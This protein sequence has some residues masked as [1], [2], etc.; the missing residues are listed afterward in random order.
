MPRVCQGDL[1]GMWACTL[2]KSTPASTGEIS[3]TRLRLATANTAAIRTNENNTD[4]IKWPPSSS[5]TEGAQTRRAASATRSSTVENRRNLKRSRTGFIECLG[6]ARIH[7]F[8]FS[9][10]LCPAHFLQDTLMAI[11][12]ITPRGCQ[13]LSVGSVFKMP[14]GPPI[15][16]QTPSPPSHRLHSIVA[17]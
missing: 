7:S 8:Q 14:P 4:K 6:C 11:D 15:G 1:S 3:R 9:E 17:S 5:S 13:P 10:R 2:P 16:P 12:G